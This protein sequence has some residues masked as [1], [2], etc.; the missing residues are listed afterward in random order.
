M[1]LLIIKQFIRS[2][3]VILTTILILVLGLISIFIGNQFLVKQEKAIAE[4]TRHQQ[5]HIERNV[6]WIDS[7]MGLLLYYLRFAL[8]NTPDNLTALSIGQRDVNSGIQSVTIRTLEG[9]KY[10]TDLNNPTN[11]QSGN[12]DFGFVIIYLFPLLVIAF[13]YDLL[14]E[15]KEKGTWRLVAI[16]SQSVRGYLI[17]KLSVRAALLYLALFV[18]FAIAILKLSLPINEVL[19]AFM[20]LSIL[21]LTFW[22]ALSFWIVSL[23][24]NS[25]FNLLTL[26]SLWV[27]LAILLPAS[28]NNFVANQYPVP[29]ALST[30]VKQ[31]DGYH[32]KWDMEQ[33]VTMNKF[34]AHYPEYQKY[35]LPEG[36]FS[37]LWY[38]A[39]Q[40]MGDDESRQQSEAMR[41]KIMQRERASS[42]V[43]LFVPTMHTQLIFHDLARSSL[44]DHL[45]FLD[46]TSAFHEKMRLYFYPK[47]F[48]NAS[49]S[50]VDWKQFKPEYFADK[51]DINWA[52]SM[53]PLLL[54]IIG[55]ALWSIINLKKLKVT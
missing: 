41:K 43:A 23:Q 20:A 7:D 39:M 54:F 4:V 24:R 18:L 55:F 31:R 12:L 21:Y 2:K 11:L 33:E 30:M 6:S 28:V 40:Q 15:E 44:D 38:Y 1:Y 47:I 36:N 27:A 51:P 10:D 37:W 25:S 8:I 22:L 35:P 17:K 16:Q 34:F 29:E 42:A 13:T 53:F 45:K 46:Q 50:D 32:E 3:A 9:Q 14:S 5:E 48:E 49:I 52:R 26:L 19:M